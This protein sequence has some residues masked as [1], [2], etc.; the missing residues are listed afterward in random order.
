MSNYTRIDA[1]VVVLSSDGY[2]DFWSIFLDFFEKNSGLTE[3][4][5][6][7][8]SEK[9]SYDH[10]H[11]KVINYPHLIGKSWSNRIAYGLREIDHDYVVIF[12]EDLLCTRPCSQ[13]D[14]SHLSEYFADHDATYIRL[15][16]V[17]PPSTRLKGKFSTLDPYALHRVSLQP[18]L[19]K[20]SRLLELM[21][22]DETPQEFEING[23]RRSR[24]DPKFFCANEPLLDYLEVIGRGMVT[25][26]G[27]NLIRNA[28]LGAHLV[29]P[30][31]S[32][33]G[34]M[35]RDLS[36]LKSRM[37]YALPPFVQT[38]LIHKGLVGRAFRD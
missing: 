29:R 2:S 7:L 6:Y 24:S 25:R 10:Q 27:A 19:W 9:K 1:A 14:W 11:L 32:P 35:Q 22:N 26:K 34:E 23:S 4:P 13:S 5:L 30:L 28:G 16:P 36:H 33:F 17:P 18:S 15:A 8:L 3:L 37:F 38:Y 12:T 31:Y 20:R 21:Q